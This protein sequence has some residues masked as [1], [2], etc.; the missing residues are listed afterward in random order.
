MCGVAG[1][2]DMSGVGAEPVRRM[3]AAMRHRGPDGHGVVSVDA[4]S[5]KVHLGHSRLKVIDTSDAGRQPMHDAARGNWL[6]FNGEVYNHGDL[7]Q[8]LEARGE[9]FGSRTDSEVVLKALSV[10]GPDAV[11]DFRGMFA[12]AFWEAPE[13]RLHLVRDRLGLKPLYLANTARGDVLFASE[14][15]AILASGLVDRR[16]DPDGLAIYLW[17]GF[18]VAP[19]TL[20]R[21]VRSLLPATRLV[22]DRTG[23]ECANET[24]W[25][26]PAPGTAPP[27]RDTMPALRAAFDEAVAIR[28]AADVPLGAFLSGGLDSSAIVATLARDDADLHAFSLGFAEAE[29]D[30]SEHARTLSRAAGNRHTVISVTERMFLDDATEALAA[31]DQPSFDGVNSWF[32]SKVAR[33]AGLTVALSG[34]GADE[35]FGGYSMF[36]QLPRLLRATRVASLLPPTLRRKIRFDSSHNHT[37]R[38]KLTDLLATAPV[39]LLDAYQVVNG[40]LRR[41]FIDEVLDDAPGSHGLCGLPRE[42]LDLTPPAEDAEGISRVCLQLFLAERCLRDVDQ[43]SMA[44]SLEVRAP[45]TDHVFLERALAVPAKIRAAGPPQKPFEAALFADRVPR[46]IRQRQKQGFTMPLGKWLRHGMLDVVRDTLLDRE[47]VRS[48][49]LAAVPIERLFRD[50]ERGYPGAPWSRVW[51]LT[52]LIDWCTRHRVVRGG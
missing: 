3:T 40:L 32:V 44:S 6:A 34:L 37:G 47:R 31:F 21:G 1:L 10:D 46:S 24:Y 41:D 23:N 30:E 25:H 28:R 19:R 14:V 20:V 4:G 38:G 12:F 42:R 26:P 35:V 8:R 22:F 9:L 51:A 52:V 2:I 33:E 11:D 50:F 15:R 29:F 17:N 27:D 39:S 13:Q 36:R 48:V 43:T 5:T 18:T 16:L 49:G 7:R 45:F